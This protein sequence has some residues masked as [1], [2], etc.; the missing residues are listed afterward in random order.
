MIRYSVVAFV[1]C[2]FVASAAWNASAETFALQDKACQRN[3]RVV[4]H[5]EIVAQQGNPTVAALPALMSFWGATNWQLVKSSRFTYSEQPDKTEITSDDLGQPRRYYQM[6]WNAPKAKKITVEQTMDVELTCFSTLYTAAKLPYADGVL[7]RLSSSLGA[8]EK[9]GINPN[10]PSLGPI[11]DPIVKRSRSAEEVVEGVC[12][13]I[14]ENIKF[15]KGQR[16]SDEALAQRQGSCT[17]MSRLACSMLR[18]IGIPAE[19]VDA[20][21]IGSENGHA[22]IEVYFPDAGWIFYD[23]SNWNR[24]YKCLDCLMTVGWAYR[25]GTPERMNWTDGHFCV[26]KDS[27]PFSDRSEIASRLIRKS[28][29]GMKVCS[30]TV[31]AQRPPSS[32][33]LRHGSLKDLIL[34]TTIPPGQ[35]GYSDDAVKSPG[36]TMKSGLS[37]K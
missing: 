24:G 22:F 2:V 37:G 36:A 29:K 8:D 10:N 17:P 7:K 16:T 13:W 25:S 15:V 23:L 33:K 20:K 30:V 1:F 26:E 14:N 5:Y 6:T 12:D 28:P 32:V 35:R 4:R 3:L 18:R 11:I 31:V 19:M 9:E 27:A 21:F 34:D